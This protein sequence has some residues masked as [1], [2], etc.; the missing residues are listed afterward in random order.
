MGAHMSLE[1]PMVPQLT[2]QLAQPLDWRMKRATYITDIE[3]QEH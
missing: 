3:S 2:E 1:A